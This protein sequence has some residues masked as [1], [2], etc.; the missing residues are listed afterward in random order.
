MFFCISHPSFANTFLNQNGPILILGDSMT[1]GDY[2]RNL[3][4]M[5]AEKTGRLVMSIGIGGA[6]SADYLRTEIENNCCGYVIRESAP[7]GSIVT[8][9]DSNVL[10]HAIVGK[11]FHGNLREMLVT[12]RPSSVL[13]VLGTNQKNAHEKLIDEIRSVLPDSVI[14]WAGPP[15]LSTSPRIYRDLES[16][17]EGKGVQLIRCDLFERLGD[18]NETMLHY[19]GQQASLLAEDT[20]Y[21]LK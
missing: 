21:Q 15:L 6:G 18:P 12:I 2:G 13:I 11:V 8:V 4:Q 20:L 7:Y 14:A 3:H 16:S 5:L 10:D 19:A 9:E 17:L 1:K